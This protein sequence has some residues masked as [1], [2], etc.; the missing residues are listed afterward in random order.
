VSENSHTVQPD[1]NLVIC[2]WVLGWE[3]PEVEFRG[4]IGGIADGQKTSV[5]L[6]N[7]KVDVWDSSRGSVDSEC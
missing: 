1:G 2:I 5:G 7:V 6:A 4:L 3:E